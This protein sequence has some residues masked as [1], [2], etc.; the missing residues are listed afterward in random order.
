MCECQ[1]FGN[2]TLLYLKGFIASSVSLVLSPT[3][4]PSFLPFWSPSKAGLCDGHAQCSDGSDE[5]GAVELPPFQGKVNNWEGRES[6][7]SGSRGRFP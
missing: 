6:E 3:L 2:R 7:R 5:A 4:S 1:G